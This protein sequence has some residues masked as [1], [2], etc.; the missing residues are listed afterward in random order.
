M[1]FHFLYEDVKHLRLHKLLDKMAVGLVLGGLAESLLVENTWLAPAAFMLHVA[2][3]VA[4]RVHEE[5]QEGLRDNPVQLLC[6]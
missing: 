4:H 2:G 1:L 3:K 5:R 6:S